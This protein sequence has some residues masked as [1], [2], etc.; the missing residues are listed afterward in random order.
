MLTRFLQRFTSSDPEP[1]IVER[2][3]GYVLVTGRTKSGQTVTIEVSKSV[4]TAY[5]AGNIISDDIA[6]MPLQ[7]FKRSGESIERIIPKTRRKNI[8]YLLEI[9]PNDFGWT[10]FLFKKAAIQWLLFYGNAYIWSPPIYPPQKFILPGDLTTPV[11]DRDGQLWYE[12]RFVDGKTRY[13]PDVE[14]LHLMINPDRTGFSGRGVIEYARETLG[15]QLGAYET[16]SNLMASGFNP[17]MILKL[18]GE[19]DK[20]GREKVREAYE[21]ALGGSGKAGGVAVF[22]R[23]VLEYEPIE[24]K[25]VDM[26]FIE[27]IRANDQDIANFFG[28]PL[29]MLNMG[30][31][32]Y[33]SNEQKYL[34][35]LSGTLDAH[36]VQFEQA[37]RIRWLPIAQQDSTYFKFNR[38]A[39]L[40]MDAQAR[41][42]TNEIR[43]RSATMT[44]N[45]AR[46]LDEMSA[47]DGGD[48]FYMTLNYEPID[49][50]PIGGENAQ[51]NE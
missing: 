18:A 27:S 3:G 48:Q 46:A 34:E 36:L 33:N 44:P 22:D 8:A 28:M 5:R 42:E 17:S 16:E 14:V 40:R 29:H 25:L 39:L 21:E 15:R 12:V 9:S 43:I 37:A 26:Q 20:A 49:Q 31:E 30:K 10:P 7:M 35:Y 23:R 38:N 24:M 41:A 11:L 51:E 47:Y 19:L 2:P 50:R 6:K 13:L 45:E 4:A 1:Q 32:A